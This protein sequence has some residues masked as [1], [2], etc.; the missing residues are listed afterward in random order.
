MPSIQARAT[1][2]SLEASNGKAYAE[3]IVEAAPACQRCAS[4][5]G[6]GAGA[7]RGR[8]ESCQVRVEV[9][10]G[11]GLS[12]GDVVNVEAGG[13]SLLRASAAAYGLPLAGMLAGAV[14]GA[15]LSQSEGPVIAFAVLGLVAGFAAGKRSLRATCWQ[16]QL[17][18]AGPGPG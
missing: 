18:L 3:L 13:Q 8:R 2:L 12:A 1:V 16:D 5:R 9:P 11:L 7:F 10:D 6:C 14:T 17:R 4:G 15:L